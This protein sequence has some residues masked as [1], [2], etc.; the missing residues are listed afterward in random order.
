[1]NR[2]DETAVPKASAGG[3]ESGVPAWDAAAEG[4]RARVRFGGRVTRPR[5]REEGLPTAARLLAETLQNE[6]EALR[7]SLEVSLARVA[8]RV[9]MLTGATREEGCTTILAALAFN[10]AVRGGQRVLVVD[11]NLRHPSVHGVFGHENDQGLGDALAGRAEPLQV[12]SP[13]AFPGLSVMLLGERDLLPADLFGSDGVTQ[14]ISAVKEQY[15][16]VLVDAPAVLAVPEVA[17]LAG[18]VD[19]VVLIARAGRTKRETL[20]KARRLLERTGSSVLGVVLNR[21]RYEIPTVF[22]KRV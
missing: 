22:Y 4:R 2:L 17:V 14:L 18:E 8:H 1:M 11:T 21:R 20:M 13:T 19:G 6:C 12:I 10:L 5:E 3:E 9:V 15:D 7:S 16:Y